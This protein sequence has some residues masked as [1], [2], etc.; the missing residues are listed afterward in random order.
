[1]NYMHCAIYIYSLYPCITIL[2]AKS[3]T[4]TCIVTIPYCLLHLITSMAQDTKPHECD[5]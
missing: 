5:Y 2:V 1:M 3:I 4:C